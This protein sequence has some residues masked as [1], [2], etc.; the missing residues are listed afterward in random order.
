MLSKYKHIQLNTKILENYLTIGMIDDDLKQQLTVK[1]TDLI[2]S[3]ITTH[4]FKDT[5][6]R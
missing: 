3:P 6:S 2:S 1:I 5:D 4:H